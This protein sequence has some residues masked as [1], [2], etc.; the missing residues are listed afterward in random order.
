MRNKTLKLLFVVFAAAARVFA[1]ADEPIEDNSFLIEEAYNQEPGVVQHISAFS[2]SRDGSWLY[3]FT[4]EAPLKSRRHQ[5][6]LTVPALKTGSGGGGIGD[7][8]VNYRCQ[9]VDNDRTAVAPRFSV[10]LP[11]GG[12]RRERGRGGV[13]L[14]FNLPLSVRLAPRFVAHTNAGLTLTPRAEN[15][16]G[17]RARAVDFNFGQSLVYLA[18]PRFNL[19]LETVWNNTETVTAFRQTRRE[20]EVLINPGVRWAHNFGW[21]DLQIVPGVAFPIGVGPSR[22]ERGVF[23]YLS[24]EHRVGKQ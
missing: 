17:A 2:R 5:L 23:L 24:F 8:A 3:T 19:I 1:Q 7:I 11:S 6:S 4:E 12:A 15:P 13:G 16:G 22:G 21:R 18:R 10:I 9:L 20:N 14:Q